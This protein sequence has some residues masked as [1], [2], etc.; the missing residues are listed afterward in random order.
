MDFDKE[1]L[2]GFYKGI[3][4]KKAERAELSKQLQKLDDEL[5][6]SI[7]EYRI[8]SVKRVLKYMANMEGSYKNMSNLL[9]HCINKLS[10]NI[11]GVELDLEENK[12]VKW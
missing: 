3:K 11:D 4:D 8:H 1:N 9:N 7:F 6:I 10:G 5:E 2:L 12:N